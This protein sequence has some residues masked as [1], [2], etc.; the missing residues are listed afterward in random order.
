[1]QLLLFFVFCL[2]IPLLSFNENLMKEG[3]SVYITENADE[4]HAWKLRLIQEA[5]S[6]LEISTGYCLGKVF[7]EMLEAIHMKLEENSVIRIHLT[8]FQIMDFI[9][10]EN[11]SF[12]YAL[13]LN[14][15]E[16]F[17]FL[18]TSGSDFLIYDGKSYFTENQT[19]LII[20]DEKYFLLGGT[21]LVDYL[22]TS[23]IEKAPDPKSIPTQ[24]LPRASYDMDAIIMGPMAKKIRKDFFDL[25]ALYLSH[26]SLDSTAGEYKPLETA[27]FP[28]AEEDRAC[29]PFFDQNPG[30]AHSAK[31]YA[32][33]AGPRIKLHTI[34]KMYEHL[35]IKSE[36]SIDIGNMYFFPHS[37]IY[38]ELLKAINRNVS[39]S[40]VTNGLHNEAST[41][42]STRSFYG[43]MN[44]VNY[45]PI[46][47][48]KRYHLWDLF[49]AKTA[50]RKNVRIY[51]LDRPSILYH[52]KV[53]T[54]DN[55]YSIVGSYNLGMKSEDAAHEACAIIE[56]HKVASKIKEIL[57]KDQDDSSEI[58]F[59]RALGWYFNPYYNI[60]DSFEKKFFDGT[61][62]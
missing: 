30:T 46:M 29:I 20:A 41:S 15:P 9:S 40:L 39:F 24:F 34:G 60:I 54:V 27:Y 44:R 49:D 1:M 59:T 23:D 48:G 62:L 47:T 33:I 12:I 28:V 51:E 19:K 16:R 7:E 37:T 18:I 26:E 45:F 61:L 52:K 8:L 6:S 32:T 53:M 55:R 4:T 13:Q 35:I 17:D 5:K 38:N 14:Y 58:S 10:E 31:V 11:Y 3:H 56:S 2:H 21:N 42:N 25:Y 50:E 43:H 36:S 22:S 57:I